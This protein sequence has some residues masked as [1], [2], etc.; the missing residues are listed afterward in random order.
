[1]TKPRQIEDYVALLS[2]HD[3]SPV[4][5]DDVLETYDRLGD[6]GISSFTL[7]VTPLFGQKRSNNIAG[8]DLLCEYLQSLNLELSLHGY[9]HVSKSSKFGEF[10]RIPQEKAVQKLRSSIAL[11]RKGMG[12]MPFGFVPPLWRAP[13]RV[14]E[15]VEGLN[16]RYC[17]IGNRL[18]SLKTQD[19]FESVILVVNQEGSRSSQE[20]ATVEIELGGSIQIALHPKDHESDEIYRTIA[21]MKDRLGYRFLGYNDYLLSQ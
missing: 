11:F 10:E 7:L 14:A 1:M 12:K 6:L 18:Y 4:Y 20:G 9:T 15:A 16:L 19:V 17:V 2:L 8:H 3:V 13:R 5:E 21:D